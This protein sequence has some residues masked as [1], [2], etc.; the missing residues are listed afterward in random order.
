[1]SFF[2][3]QFTQQIITTPLG[4]PIKSMWQ[5]PDCPGKPGLCPGECFK[6]IHTKFYFTK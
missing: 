2:L 3:L 4:H 5:C 6:K 1:M